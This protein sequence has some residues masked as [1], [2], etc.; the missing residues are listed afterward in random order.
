MKL[1][2]DIFTDNIVYWPSMSHLYLTNMIN[3]KNDE[4]ET[5]EEFII[6]KN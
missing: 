5:N 4:Q 3:K 2:D 1:F 6:F